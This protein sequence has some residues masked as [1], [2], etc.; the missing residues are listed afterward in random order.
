MLKKSYLKL[1]EKKRKNI[2]GIQ[3]I[4]MKVKPE[5]LSQK[6]NG[7]NGGRSEKN[8]LRTASLKK[9]KKELLAYLNVYKLSLTLS[10]NFLP[11]PLLLFLQSGS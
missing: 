3:K 10:C 5:I 9:K 4:Y 1:W 6:C 11:L 7:G 8:L 2:E